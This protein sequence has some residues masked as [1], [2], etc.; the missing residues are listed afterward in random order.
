[1]AYFRRR[2]G[3]SR[4]K[5]KIENV[6]QSGNLVL[7]PINNGTT[8]SIPNS[9]TYSQIDS[10]YPIFDLNECYTQTMNGEGNTQYTIVHL[11]IYK[12]K[13]P[14]TARSFRL[15]GS[16]TIDLP[17]ITVSNNDGFS[18]PIQ[19]YIQI[20]RAGTFPHVLGGYC[21]STTIQTVTSNVGHR[22]SG[23]PKE[24]VVLS[25]GYMNSKLNQTFSFDMNSTTKRSLEDGDLVMISFILKTYQDS[26]EIIPVVG[27]FNSQV[28]YAS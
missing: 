6:K 27:A 10:C 26:Q 18:T 7:Y 28:V 15:Q 14:V 4:K 17:S 3:Y 25:S 2:G 16:L 13:R 1:M 21:R 5:L 9:K 22:T 8:I 12:A 23:D 20:V 19:C 24:L 11:P